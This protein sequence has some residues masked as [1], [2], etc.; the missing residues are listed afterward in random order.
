MSISTPLGGRGHIGPRW[1]GTYV[2]VV[3][4]TGGGG[5]LLHLHQELDVV[6]GLLQPF[7]QQLERLLSVEAREHPA[8]LPD[9][10]QLLLAHE[11]LFT[12]SSGLYG[13][14][15]REDPLVREIAPQPDLHVA[16]ALE[17]LED[18]LVH[19]RATFDE[20]SRENGQRS[21]VL[22]VARGAE[23]LLRR[24]ERSRVDTTGQDPAARRRGEVVGATQAGDPV[25]EHHDVVT[26]LDKTLGPLD[27]QLGH[28][29]VIGG[30]TVERR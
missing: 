15:G 28:D 5:G 16:G 1:S 7:Q 26:E 2:S 9:D 3:L 13:V 19:L 30:R 22:D 24:V 10:G 27:G 23:E 25:E 8:E 20:G 4:P 21:A 29:R 17:L 14:D 11:Q 12:T 6:L 18:D